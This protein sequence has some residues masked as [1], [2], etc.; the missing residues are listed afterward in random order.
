VKAGAKI[1]AQSK[2]GDVAKGFFYPATLMVD[3]DHTM[4]LMREETFGPV[5]P[6]MKFRTIEE[7]IAL[8]ND[9]TMA[10]TSSVWT[11]D[12]ALGKEIA[13]KLES[14][15]TTINDHLY[16]HGQ[17][18]TPW[19]GWKESGLGRTHSALGLDEMTHAKLINWDLLP[20]K[21][22]IWWFPFD[23]NTYE[24]L[25]AALRA[26]FPESVGGRARDATVLSKLM[27]GKM[28]SSWKAKPE[29]ES[30]RPPKP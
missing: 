13:R 22:N 6:V 4:D 18:E 10:L 25:L 30:I 29:I 9:S 27:L 2:A 7:A 11:K 24:G 20:S 5:L 12:I 21:R 16:T 3:V 23:V 1:V 26:S 8:A 17:S 28:F 19:G 15:V 14:G